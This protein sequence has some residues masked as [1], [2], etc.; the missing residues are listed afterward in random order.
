MQT[1]LKTITSVS[2][3]IVL[4]IKADSGA[5]ALQVLKAWVTHLELPRGKLIAVDES[6]DPVEA[7]TWNGTLLYDF[8]FIGLS[9]INQCHEIMF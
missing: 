4:G 9:L 6:N 3:S 7:D 5:K 8:E 1:A 2:S